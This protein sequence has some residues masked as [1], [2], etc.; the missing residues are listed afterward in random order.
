MGKRKRGSKTKPGITC[1]ADKR[2]M[3]S[4]L[5]FST[6]PFRPV[7]AFWI[8]DVPS[9][10]WRAGHAHR[11]CV[12]AIMMIS[13]RCRAEFADDAGSWEKTLYAGKLDIVYPGVWARYGLWSPH[14]SMLVLC[15]RPYEPDDYI[16]EIP[17][18]K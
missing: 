14:A 10:T 6:L 4:V 2:G 15:S 11:K 13:G 9:G 12:Q 16:V 17:K 7:R 5:E 1:H 18:L 3:L 8:R